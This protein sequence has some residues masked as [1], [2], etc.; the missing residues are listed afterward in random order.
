VNLLLAIKIKLKPLIQLLLAGCIL[1]S[2]DTYAAELSASELKL[3]MAAAEELSAG[4]FPLTKNEQA[5]ICICVKDKRPNIL[6]TEKDWDAL[7]PDSLHVTLLE[8]SEKKLYISSKKK[9]NNYYQELA[10]LKNYNDQDIE[11]IRKC[12]FNAL[13]NSVR[14]TII[15]NGAMNPSGY[16]RERSFCK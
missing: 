8:C 1:L 14:N 5:E 9:D 6:Q 7:G 4:L 11:R 3:C 10:K 13:Y 12:D 2:T 15:N 16:Y